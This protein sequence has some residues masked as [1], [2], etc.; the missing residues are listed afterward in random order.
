MTKETKELTTEEIEFLARLDAFVLE[1]GYL[2]D[3]EIMTTEQGGHHGEK[4]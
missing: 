4:E 1:D 3:L 2:D